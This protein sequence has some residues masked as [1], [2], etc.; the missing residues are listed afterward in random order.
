MMF[1]IGQERDEWKTKWEK[2]VFT[3]NKLVSILLLGL[4]VALIATNFNYG[5]FRVPMAVLILI[6]SFDAWVFVNM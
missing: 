3:I 1:V 6:A 2:E 4:A 5:H